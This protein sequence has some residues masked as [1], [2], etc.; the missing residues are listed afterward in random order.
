MTFASTVR[1]AAKA[2]AAATTYEDV[3]LADSPIAYWRLGESSG[4]TAVDSSGN[5]RDGTYNGPTLGATGL[6]S[7]DADTAANFDGSNDRVYWADAAWMDVTG[8]LTVEAWIERVDVAGNNDIV[9]RWQGATRGRTFVLLLIDDDAYFYVNRGGSTSYFAQ[10]TSAITA[11]TPHHVV[12]RYDSSTGEVNVLVDGVEGATTD[13]TGGGNLAANA[14][15]MFIGMRASGNA[16]DDPFAWGPFDGTIDEVAIYNSY[17][18]NARIQA[19]YNA[20]T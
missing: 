5:N 2:A 12:G 3:V 18:S 14:V 4:T 17:L 9:A 7:G 6:L 8:D 16:G 20:G 10:A 15:E 13:S 1:L 19:H 11:N